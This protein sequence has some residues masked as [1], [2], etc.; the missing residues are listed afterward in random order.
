MASDNKYVKYQ[1]K[2]VKIVEKPSV[3]D[4]ISVYARPGDLVDFKIP[5]VNFD[6]LE[7]KLVGGDI[8]VDIPGGGSITFVSLAIMGFNDNPPNISTTSGKI[9]SLGDILSEVENINSMPLDSLVSNIDV[10]IPDNTA[11][12]NQDG[13][14]TQNN[15]A[16]PQVI[17]QEVELVSDSAKDKDGDVPDVFEIPPV[18]IP[19]IIPN[20][21]TSNEES[22]LTENSKVEGVKPSLKFDI[23]IQH[24]TQELNF[25]LKDNDKFMNVDGGGGI[26]YKNTYEVDPD[27]LNSISDDLKKQRA[28]E[29]IDYRDVTD[30]TADKI[31]INADEKE[32]FTTGSSLHDSNLNQENVPRT[33]RKIVLTPKQ[34]EG[35]NVEEIKI[36]SDDFPEGFK[37]ANAVESNGVFT[38][39]KD[40]PETDEIEGF[41]LTKTGTIEIIFTLNT[42]QDININGDRDFVFTIDGKA[43]FDL[44]NIPEE[45]RTGFTPPIEKELTFEKDYGINFRHVTNDNDLSSYKN[46]NKIEI[47]GK[48]T[49]ET[50]FVV[51]TNINDN[52]IYGS[53]TLENE[54][55]GGIG[56]DTILGG[57]NKD[58]I[59]SNE[60]NDTITL[61]LGDDIVDGGEGNDTLDFSSINKEDS[62][63]GINADLETGVIT[64]DGTDTVSN[65]ENITGTQDKDILRGDEKVNILKGEDHADTLFGN[66]GN[67]TLEGG[68]GSDTL[69]GGLGDDSLDGGLGKDTVSY[70][71]ASGGV[72]VNLY[73]D[74]DNEPKL[75]EATGADGTDKL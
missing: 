68:A 64:G 32:Y 27:E 51:T 56:K 26:G 29:I 23:D 60:G 45:D 37:I 49:L 15:K 35:F 33:S 3:D 36:S 46:F 50:G 70:E 42:T 25:E 54:I 73:V 58:T 4:N 1:N 21:F 5:G 67:D 31:V 47:E 38:L 53:N 40:D 24:L 43:V 59:F 41:Q 61:G 28:Q 18:D 14:D 69:E 72:N 66:A 57:K 6:D 11:E 22:T 75:G 16:S 13:D 10:N 65:I 9:I 20:D 7:K 2:S 52:L 55:H 30:S 71:N 44:E 39:E 63:E 17:I 48:E 62:S 12:D 8:V 34:P 19:D 74:P